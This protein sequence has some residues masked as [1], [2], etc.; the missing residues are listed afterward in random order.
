MLVPSNN[1]TCTDDA[2]AAY[3]LVSLSHGWNDRFDRYSYIVILDTDTL[4]RNKTD[5]AVSAVQS[6]SNI[7]GWSLR[8]LLALLAYQH[9]PNTEH[10]TCNIVSLRGLLLSRLL[11]FNDTESAQHFLNNCDDD[12]LCK[13]KP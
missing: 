2:K 4:L 8:N 3:Q 13:Y 9:V 11:S 5:D 6:P 7:F 1:Q 12:H 10:N